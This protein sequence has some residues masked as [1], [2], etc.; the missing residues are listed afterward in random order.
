MA[1][2]IQEPQIKSDALPTMDEMREAGQKIEE[3]GIG[4]V[5]RGVY[6]PGDQE[7][8]KQEEE[9]VNVVDQPPVKVIPTSKK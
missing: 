3:A 7:V 9:Q 6:P 5:L 2:N 1:D 4:E 8:L